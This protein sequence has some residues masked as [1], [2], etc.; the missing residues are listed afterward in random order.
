MIEG[1]EFST[2]TLHRS[3]FIFICFFSNVTCLK[4]LHAWNKRAWRN[5]TRSAVIV[6]TE[7]LLHADKSKSFGESREAEAAE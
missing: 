2:T 5:T 4:R 6:W 1:K 7:L 3:R